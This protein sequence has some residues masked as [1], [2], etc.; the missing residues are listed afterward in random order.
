MSTNESPIQLI[1]E[2]E[3]VVDG[4][5]D[6]V[7]APLIV[8]DIR[9]RLP[10]DALA[11]RVGNEIRIAVKIGRGNMRP[12]REVKRGQL[13]YLPLGD[14]IC[15]YTADMTTFSPVSVIGR[16]TSPDAILDTLLNTRRSARVRIV[17]R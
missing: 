17:L 6:R 1:F 11:A 8:E 12:L 14:A 16:I 10:L 4:V 15:I 9:A 2:N 7:M 3:L 13:A 5:L